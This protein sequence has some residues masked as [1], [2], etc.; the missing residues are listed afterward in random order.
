MP[1]APQA[2]APPQ[3]VSVG[4]RRWASILVWLAVIIAVFMV[5]ALVASILLLVHAN[6]DTSNAAAGYIAIVLWAV[7]GA[8]VP[9]LLAVAIPGVLM[10]RRVREQRQA[11]IITS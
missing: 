11:G 1:S 3:A 2:Y 8:A 10:K 5:V 7:I 9:V 4:Y 6:A